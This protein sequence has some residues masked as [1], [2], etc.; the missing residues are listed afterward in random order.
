MVMRPAIR[1]ASVAT[2]AVMLA[3][4]ACGSAPTAKTPTPPPARTCSGE[5]PA[6]GPISITLPHD[7]HERGYRLYVPSGYDH[8]A[9]T[10][11]LLSFHTKVSSYPAEVR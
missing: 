3:A 6:T 8:T 7:G 2:G 1:T 9:P 10:P 11:L 5:G 4:S